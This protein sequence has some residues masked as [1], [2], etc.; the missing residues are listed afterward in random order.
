MVEHRVFQHHFTKQNMKIRLKIT[1]EN[2]L[3]V[4]VM[5][6]EYTWYI[7]RRIAGC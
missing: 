2:C 5:L 6:P 7:F 1:R 3:A 4:L